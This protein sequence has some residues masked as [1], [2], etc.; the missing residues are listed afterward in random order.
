MKI[1]PALLLAQFAGTFPLFMYLVPANVIGAGFF[2][3]NMALVTI[4]LFVAT[5]LGLLLGAAGPLK[6]LLLGV[7]GASLVLLRVTWGQPQLGKVLL[8]PLLILWGFLLGWLL[9][10]AQILDVDWRHWM[11]LGLGGAA[12]GAALF[13]MVLGHQY[14]NVAGLP[15]RHLQRGARL[16][17][18][19]L[20]AR[21]AWLAL[22]LGTGSVVLG[23]RV[24]PAYLLLGG[25]QGVLLWI[26]LLMGVA[27]PIAVT[28]MALKSA[29]IQSTQSATGLLYVVLIQVLMGTLIFDGYLL[30]LNL[31]L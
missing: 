23:Q 6:I 26:G 14:L 27:A 28:W 24:Q 1:L 20:L 4:L 10:G 9:L 30:E 25:L 22:V 16:L 13:A 3:F 5:F 2:R 15:I 21:L 29:L 17:L 18:W 31:P 11:G 12:L 8:N 19:M 7:G